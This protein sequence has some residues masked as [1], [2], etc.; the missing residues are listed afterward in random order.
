V[1]INGVSANGR[2]VGRGLD[3]EVLDGRFRERRGGAGAA[4]ILTFKWPVALIAVPSGFSRSSANVAGGDLVYT[5]YP[6]VGRLR[7]TGPEPR[8][9]N[10]GYPVSQSFDLDRCAGTPEDAPREWSPIG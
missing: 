10:S 9:Q 4:G 3:G 6:D 8:W 5:F 1:V 2:V 7:L